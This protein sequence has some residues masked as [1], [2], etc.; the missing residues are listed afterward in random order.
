MPRAKKRSETQVPTEPVPDFQQDELPQS[1][2]EKL[3]DLED[4]GLR[5]L[6]M[7]TEPG[8][9]ALALRTA[10]EE[11]RR[12]ILRVLPADRLQ[13]L[14]DHPDFSAPARLSDIEAAQLEMLDLLDIPEP[15]GAEPVGSSAVSV[16]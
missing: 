1:P 10:P 14:Q 8:I 11:L 5:I 12:R 7:R 15:V 6:L 3:M 16:T 9:I 2:F 13:A 4:A